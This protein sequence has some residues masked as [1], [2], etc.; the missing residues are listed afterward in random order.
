MVIDAKIYIDAR[1]LLDNIIDMTLM[2]PRE[3]KFTIGVR[4]QSL[5][6]DVLEEITAA[7]INKDIDERTRH[8]VVFQQ[9]FQTL[10]T[11]VRIAGERRWIQGI[12]RLARV[13]EL[14]DGIGRQGNAWK[15]SLLP[16]EEGQAG[17][18]GSRPSQESGSS[19]ANGA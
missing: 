6:I 2:F 16:S 12:G 1:H 14:M 11:L 3:Y 7:Y 17:I 15:N 10:Q 5:A 19:N 18:G 13:I 8:L 9:K 4:M